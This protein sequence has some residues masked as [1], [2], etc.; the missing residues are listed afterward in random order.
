VKSNVSCLFEFFISDF[1]S[2]RYSSATVI[3]L[4]ERR[5]KKWLKGKNSQNDLHLSTVPSS[6]E[7]IPL[8]QINLLSK[9]TAKQKIQ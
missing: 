1:S 7:I 6:S 2:A 3:A 5:A 8:D 9:E 4:S